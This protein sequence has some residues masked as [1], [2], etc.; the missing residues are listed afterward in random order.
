MP[1]FLLLLCI[2]IGSFWNM[3]FL[4]E[5]INPTIAIVYSIVLFPRTRPLLNVVGWI[6]IIVFQIAVSIFLHSNSD[7]GVFAIVIEIVLYILLAI[8]LCIACLFF[9]KHI[10]IMK[11]IKNLIVGH[12]FK[13][14]NIGGNGG[15]NKANINSTIITF[16][17]KKQGNAIDFYT[18]KKFRYKID[19][20]VLNRKKSDEDEFDEDLPTQI[21]FKDKESGT[22]V[23]FDC[24]TDIERKELKLGE[25][26][27]FNDN[28]RGYTNET[29]D[30]ILIFEPTYTF[31]QL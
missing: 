24:Q 18:I 14:V 23:K 8:N 16:N 4:A 26:Y 11:E 3:Y 1:L 12:T 5:Y 25:E 10:I 29:G 30:L 20:Q 21:K 15:E 2:G 27:A 9:R 7:I 28:V 22:E 13:L 31:H 17:N 19:T 6:T